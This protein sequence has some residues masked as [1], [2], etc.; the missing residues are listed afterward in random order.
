[1][2]EDVEMGSHLEHSLLL[3]VMRMIL[4][5]PFLLVKGNKLQERVDSL[6]ER[7]LS[8]ESTNEAFT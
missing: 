5:L 7:V 1:M 2:V 8:N 6:E 4:P 3:P